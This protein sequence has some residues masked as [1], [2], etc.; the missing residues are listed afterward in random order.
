MCCAHRISARSTRPTVSATTTST[1]TTLT[2][3][4]CRVSVA[5]VGGKL[6]AFDDLYEGLPV[7]RR[8]AHGTTMMSQCDG[9]QFDLATGA[10][11]RGPATR[12]LEIYPVREQGGQIEVCL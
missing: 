8:P 3:C 10:V 1:P 11:L 7:V 4:S 2:I 5:R 12:A 6:Y 9:S